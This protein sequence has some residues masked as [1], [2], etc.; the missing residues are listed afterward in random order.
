MYVQYQESRERFEQQRALD[1]A[2][3]THRP[4]WEDLKQRP[5]DA[6]SKLIGG[7]QHDI[8]P[9]GVLVVGVV[10][11]PINHFPVIRGQVPTISTPKGKI[12]GY[13]SPLTAHNDTWAGL[14]DWSPVRLIGVVGAGIRV[15]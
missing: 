15:G 8:D 11:L 7:I 3:T 2:T 5:C 9:G 1:V 13:L 10:P 14:F 4:D 6:L 12:V